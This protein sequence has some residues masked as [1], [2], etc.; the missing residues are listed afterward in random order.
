MFL[1]ILRGVGSVLAGLVL[2]FVF[3]FAAEIFSEIVY[4]FP[5]GADTS[6]IEVVKAQVAGYPTWVL[7]AGAAFWAAAPFSGA[8]LATRLGTAHHPV[9][10]IIVGLVLLA[11]AI[12]NISMLPYP[13]WF[14]VV[15]L[16]T[17][18]LG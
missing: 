17:F 14:P 13:V 12:C 7:A 2:A 10:G 1:A 4:P 3:I 18:T 15:I 8:W 6:N 16:L 11:L 9:H 5:P